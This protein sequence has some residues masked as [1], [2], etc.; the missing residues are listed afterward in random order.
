MATHLKRFVESGEV[1]GFVALVSR[2]NRIEAE[3]AGT[4][5]RNGEPLA[6]DS[7]FRIT[8]MTKPIA[9]VATLL[10]ADQGK[11]RLQDPI[12]KWLPELADRRVLKRIDGDLAD[13]VPA[14]R[15]IRVEDL[16]SFRMGFGLIMNFS[17]FSKKYPIV[18]RFKELGLLGL[19]PP[20][21]SNP[22]TA[23]EW[24]ERFAMLP[25]MMQP[26]ELWQYNAAYYLLGIFLSRVTGKALDELFRELLFDPLGMK[27]TGFVVPKEKLGRLTDCYRFDSE[28]SRLELLDAASDSHWSRKPSF[29]DASAGLVSTVDDYLAF[30]RMLMSEG[31]HADKPFLS[32]EM[33]RAMTA[34]QL[35]P[36]QREKPTL[37]SDRWRNHG[38]G[39]GVSILMS[40]SKTGIGRAGQYGWNG[41]FGSSWLNDP[42]S[43]LI[44]ILLTERAFDSPA[45]PPICEEFWKQVYVK[46]A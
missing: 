4:R 46:P 36:D 7:I 14:K 2:E 44:G 34:N 23:D 35:T 30:A 25:L 43:R 22:L 13:T 8:S 31:Q 12:E 3:I 38:Y 37:V 33:A 11:L 19:G 40:E 18:E 29:L 26:G 15:E 28:K 42:K 39:Y 10:L 41:G 17:D 45:L 20:D 5:T 27:D 16:L 32:A 9:A 21:L 24:L 6:R 1:P